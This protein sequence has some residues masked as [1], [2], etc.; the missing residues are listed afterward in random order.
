MFI[1]ALA[2]RESLQ[3]KTNAAGEAIINAQISNRSKSETSDI[4]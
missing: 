1:A 4:C 3:P 2:T